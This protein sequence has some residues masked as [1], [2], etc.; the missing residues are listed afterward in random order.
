[1]GIGELKRDIRE[2]II[3][4][5]YHVV[6]EDIWELLDVYDNCLESA[7][8]SDELAEAAFLRG[9]VAFHM[10]RYHD[11]VKA[12]T[13]SLRI[14]KTPEYAY[15]EADAYNLLGMLFA[16]IG[17]ENIALDNYLSAVASAKKH[18]NIQGQVSALLNIGILYQGLGDYRKAMSYYKKGYEAANGEYGTPEL[19]L[20]L[21]CM[22][23]QA[24]V[25][26]KMRRFDETKR[27]KREIDSYYQVIV[28]DEIILP[29]Y[30]LEVWME[31]RT[32][33]EQH[34]QELIEE[35]RQYLIRDT[36]Y[37]EQI[38]FY[39]EFCGFL[40]ESG[41][42]ADARQFLDLL[43]EKLGA[44]EFLHL[45]MRMEE[46]E[47]Q[48]QRKYS[49]EAHY[50]EA[51]LHF[52]TLQQEYERTLKEF[53][54]QNLSNI[55]SLQELERQR[56]EF[57]FRSKCDLATGLL[58]K[59]TFQYEVEN[60][61]ADRNR[62]VTDAMIIVDIDDFKLVND[63]YGHLVGDEVIT[64]LAS[65]LR[66][67]FGE[68]ICGRFGGD[69]FVVFICDIND[70]EQVE[71]RVEQFRERFAAVG[72]GKNENIHN[73]VSIGVSYN[74]GINASYKSM[75][76]CADEALLK[77]K[78]YGKNRVAFFEIKRGLLKYV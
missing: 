68:D 69:E 46:M 20:V 10:G 41:R 53:K 26:F 7:S 11:T 74:N 28:H 72:F 65:L 33:T 37:L 54:Q 21:L 44:T 1:M 58:N 34:I 70:I 15:L 71:T 36:E 73:T 32:G 39:V 77:A 13:K 49:D 57:E 4:Y 23:Q 8:T 60:Y 42:K 76:S 29:K 38:D 64:K 66:E 14:E 31:S 59:D 17:Y 62:G 56:K 12:L 25:L 55:E 61:L 24:Q 43:T 67:Q 5:P 48:Y 9:D 35:I 16:F 27:L 50:F 63:S 45:R 47:V 40:M 18:R 19:T 2:K 52:M 6:T 51:C 22:I 30:I 78:E 75:F 3:S